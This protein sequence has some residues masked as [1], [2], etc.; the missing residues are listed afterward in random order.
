MKVAAAF[1]VLLAGACDSSGG[2]EHNSAP[3]EVSEELTTENIVANDV[4]A[5]DASPHL[6][7]APVKTHNYDFREGDVYGYFAAITEEEQKKGKGAPDVIMFRYKGFWN[8]ANHLEQ[9]DGAGRII[10]LSE[11]SDPCAAIKM[12]RYGNVERVAYSTN[13]IIGAAFEDAM[14]GRL[15]NAKPPA[16]PE[17]VPSQTTTAEAQI[18]PNADYN[19][20]QEN[21]AQ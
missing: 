3:F 19:S 2:E 14:S 12:Y 20:A 4:T 1:L 15:A 11:C 13:S 21:D 9:V 18:E 17:P 6:P 5:I 8:S 7:V 16:P 10:S